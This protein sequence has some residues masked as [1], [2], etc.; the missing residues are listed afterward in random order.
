MHFNYRD[1]CKFNACFKLS[2]QNTIHGLLRILFLL[3]KN[4]KSLFVKLK[5]TLTD[6]SVLSSN[7]SCKDGIVLFTTEPFKTFICSSNPS[8]KDGIVLFTT[9]PFKPLSVQYWG[10][11]VF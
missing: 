9:E 11:F 8:C 4:N 7:P 1:E 5:I 2:Q 6:N 3:Q 10:R